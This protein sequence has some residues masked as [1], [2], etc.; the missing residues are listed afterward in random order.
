MTKV[1]IIGIGNP[2][3]EYAETFH[4][5]GVAFVTWLAG[6]DATWTTRAHVRYTTNNDVVYAITTGYMNESGRGVRE[7]VDW[8]KIDASSVIIA[9]DD[10][11][12]PLGK[13]KLVRGGGSAGHKGIKSIQEMLGTPDFWRLKL[14]ARP[15]R[16]SG[17]PHIKA[18]NFVLNRLWDD[19][20]EMLYNDAFPEGAKLATK[21][22][23][24]VIPSGPERISAIGRVT[25]DND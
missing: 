18:E 16:F 4:N 22:I 6:E 17:T 10:T 20:R 23:E 13:I 19:E 1:A 5:E 8:L 25:P 24:N 12:Q 14:G 3:S 7:L 11:D 9:H 15:E 2:G 21:L